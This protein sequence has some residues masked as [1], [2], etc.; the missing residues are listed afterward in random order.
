MAINKD[1][2]PSSLTGYNMYVTM[3]NWRDVLYQS[4]K[5]NPDSVSY[6]TSLRTS[7]SIITLG[8]STVLSRDVGMTPCN[9]IEKLN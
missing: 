9:Y 4:H 7:H 1:S 5:K 6:L 2:M 8:K 3:P